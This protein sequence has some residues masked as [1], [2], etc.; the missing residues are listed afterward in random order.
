[1]KHF[2]A[3]T[4]FFFIFSI[5]PGTTSDELKGTWMSQMGNHHDEIQLTL[6]VRNNWNSS[7]GILVRE[8]KGLSMK[9]V[10]GTTSDCKQ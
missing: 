5:I 8:F 2:V 3:L 4:A 7:F 9:S 10:E 6:Q 1:M